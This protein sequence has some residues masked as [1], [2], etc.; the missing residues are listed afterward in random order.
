MVAISMQQK[1]RKNFPHRDTGKNK[2][3]TAKVWNKTVANLT[4]MA[5]GSSGAV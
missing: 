5:L 1:C 2:V 4:L 3:I